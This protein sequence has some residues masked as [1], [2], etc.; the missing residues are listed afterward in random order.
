MARDLTVSDPGG[1]VPGEGR[2]DARS[3]VPTTERIEFG[4]RAL[5]EGWETVPRGFFREEKETHYQVGRIWRSLLVAVAVLALLNSERLV[6]MVS[7]LSVGPVE[8]TVIVMSET[9]HQ[10]M[11]ER[12]LAQ[13]AE[14]I[15]ARI[16]A[17]RAAMW[18]DLG[19]EETG[20]RQGAILRGPQSGA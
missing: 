20:A 11:E 1:V 2:E 9:W 17:W 15:R 10:Q 13:L 14:D 16:E 8:D 18:D 19:E 4:N 6:T 3:L 5:V 7:G 12:G